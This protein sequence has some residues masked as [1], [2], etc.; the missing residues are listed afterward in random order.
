MTEDA[1]LAFCERYYIIYKYHICGSVVNIMATSPKSPSDV[2]LEVRDRF[3]RRRLAMSLTQAGLAKRS[4]VTLGSL[5]RFE[6][7]TLIAFDSLL[8]LALVLD[9]LGDFDRLAADD[10]SALTGR[11]LDDILAS[12]LPRTKGRLT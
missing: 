5:K 8:K 2:Q 9:C 12:S 1:I 6:T 7:T 3:K 11:Y 10:V 4:G